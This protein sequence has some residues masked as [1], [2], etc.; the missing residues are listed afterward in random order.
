[1]FFFFAGPGVK[2]TASVGQ[3]S[4]ACQAHGNGPDGAFSCGWSRWGRSKVLPSNGLQAEDLQGQA[5]AEQR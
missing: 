2:N 1:M 3:G 5:G 4:R